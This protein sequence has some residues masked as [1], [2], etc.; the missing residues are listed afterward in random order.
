MARPITYESREG[1][2]DKL[3]E[4]MPP[5]S[6]P[7]AGSARERRLTM[8]IWTRNVILGLAAAL[9]VGGCALGSRTYEFR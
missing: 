6:P 4:C 1:H 7:P 5:R 9:L 8:T 3:M 2:R